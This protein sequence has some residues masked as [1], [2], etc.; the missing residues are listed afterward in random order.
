[1]A[2]WLGRRPPRYSRQLDD[3][4]PRHCCPIQQTRRALTGS[5]LHRRPYPLAQ[6]RSTKHTLVRAEGRLWD[7]D[8]GP[9]LMISEPLAVGDAL[10]RAAA[11]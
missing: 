3:G 11:I 4:L 5:R 6:P 7:I 2:L 9:E 1:M 10:P 8:T